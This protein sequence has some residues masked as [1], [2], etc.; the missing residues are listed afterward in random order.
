[1]AA[2]LLLSYFELNRDVSLFPACFLVPLMFNNVSAML[3]QESSYRYC[4][5]RS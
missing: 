3:E 1:V 5:S 2:R 4:Q